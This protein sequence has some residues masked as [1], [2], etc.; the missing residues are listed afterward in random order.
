MNDIDVRDGGLLFSLI[1]PVLVLLWG[2]WGLAASLAIALAWVRVCSWGLPRAERERWVEERR[3]HL[4]EQVEAGKR[5]GY[6][7]KEIAVHVLWD[8]LRGLQD[9]VTRR[10]VATSERPKH[11]SVSLPIHAIA[12]G[13]ASGRAGP[14]RPTVECG[15][16]RAPLDEP[17]DLNP[18]DRTPCPVCGSLGR[19]FGVHLTGSLGMTGSLSTKV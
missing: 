18:A 6:A 3:S 14:A 5:D 8:S 19:H 1:I 17:P 12:S 9:D 13:R 7:P 11:A 2:A 16:C 10:A 4:W 15:Q